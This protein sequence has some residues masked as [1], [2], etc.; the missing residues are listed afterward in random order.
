M[1]AVAERT[2]DHPVKEQALP[3]GRVTELDSVRGI[4]A[5]VVLLHHLWETVLPDQ[6]T[7]PLQGY[8]VPGGG[9]LAEGAFWIS[10]TPLRLLFSGH[11]A[12]GLF[13]VLSGFALTKSLQGPRQSGYAPFLVRRFFRIYPPFALVTLLA[14]TLCVLIA[15]MAVPGRDWINHYWLTPVT[16]GLVLGHLGMID[17][18]GYYT[19]LNSSMW[20]LVHEMRISIV[21]PLVAG[22]AFVYPRTVAVASVLGFAVLSV[23]RLTNAFGAHIHPD[24]LQAF[25]MSV[26]QSLRYV[27]FF[28]FGILVATQSSLWDSLLRRHAWSRKYLWLFALGLLAIP[29]TKGYLELCY[30]VGAFVLLILCIQS[31]SARR[32]LGRPALMWL[33]KVSYS[34]YLVHLIVLIAAVYVLHDVLPIALILALVTISSLVLAEV[35]HR[36]V[37][38]PS[39]Q[40]GKRLA[41]RIET[42]RR[43]VSVKLSDDTSN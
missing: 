13:F 42:T 40:L 17:T 1:N 23:T 3:A 39:N 12:V 35:L 19:S 30:G 15:P 14:A 28:V 10:V 20:T 43:P 32:F 26:I 6:N 36:Y 9:A 34:L 22:L 16:P 27:M 24:I 5:F 33:G 8:P 2:S 38:M 37:E 4:A 25:I 21:F 7:F 31:P 18:A 11:A 41:K 29:Y